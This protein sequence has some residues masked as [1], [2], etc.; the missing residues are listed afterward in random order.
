MVDKVWVGKKVRVLSLEELERNHFKDENGYFWY[1][2]NEENKH[3]NNSL[4]RLKYENTFNA[5]MQKFC[6]KVY[7]V[8]QV[9]DSGF[10]IKEDTEHFLWHLWMVKE[11]ISIEKVLESE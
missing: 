7:E 1:S 9:R 5:T 8:S 3:G 4:Y 6:G 2:K 11:P 10:I